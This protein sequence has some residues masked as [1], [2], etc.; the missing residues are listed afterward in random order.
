MSHQL[1][2]EMQR[3]ETLMSRLREPDTGCSW[4]LQQT[5]KSIA[6]STLEEAYEVVD[7]IEREDFQ[8]LREELGDLLFQV[9]FYAQLGKEDGHF[10]LADIAKNLVDKL[11]SRHPHVFPDGTLDSRVDSNQSADTEKIKQ[12][13]ESIKENERDKK[14]ET[15]VLAGVPHTLPALVRAHKLQKRAS[16]VGFDWSDIDSIFEKITEELDELRVAIKENSQEEISAELGDVL[17]SVVNLSRHLKVEPE[18]ALRSCNRK[19][20]SRFNYVE[21]TLNE[22]GTLIKDASLEEMDFFWEESKKVEVKD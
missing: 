12:M 16:R 11:V 5:Y 6:S 2:K 13:W 7:A 1:S 14:G 17:F 20:E 4:D 10:S 19:F 3:L 21:K 9:V 22:K 8:H 15:T 18:T